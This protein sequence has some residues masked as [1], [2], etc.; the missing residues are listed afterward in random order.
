[1]A[2][3]ITITISDRGE[4]TENIVRPDG[5]C[6]NASIYARFYNSSCLAWT[7]DSESNLHYLK[8]AEAQAN[9]KLMVKKTLFLNDVYDMLGIPRSKAGMV[10]GWTYNKENP[11]GDNCVNFGIFESYNQD[12]VNGFTDYALLD[13]NVD[14]CILDYI[15]Y[16][17]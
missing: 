17:D 1:M 6:V 13:F 7:T 15:E 3:T 14:G 16:F 10:V 2:K 12:F 4:K 11:I 9:A 5:T 8:Q